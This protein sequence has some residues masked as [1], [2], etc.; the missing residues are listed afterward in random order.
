VLFPWGLDAHGGGRG[1][2]WK[3]VRPWL[4]YPAQSV[5]NVDVFNASTTTALTGLQLYFVGCKQFPPGQP[6]TTYPDKCSLLDF[7]QS[8]YSRDPVTGQNGVLG[9]LLGVNDE[10]LLV[11]INV[12]S[13]A[14]FVLRSGQAGIDG[15]YYPATSYGSVTPVPF[16]SEVFVTL[17]DQKLKAYS[18][19]PVHIDWLFGNSL[20]APGIDLNWAGYPNQEAF[21]VG[22]FHP[23]L[24]VP[25]IYIPAN[26]ALY[27]DVHRNDSA[28]AGAVPINLNIAFRGSKVFR[29]G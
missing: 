8:H 22:N 25:E 6:F 26:E 12:P 29:R 27:Y 2:A 9:G 15:T 19:A 18:N 20:R 10:R 4:P 11:P 17:R 16:Y 28:Y 1:G 7:T 21:L 13:D 24:I 23:G 3:A 14:D 5:I